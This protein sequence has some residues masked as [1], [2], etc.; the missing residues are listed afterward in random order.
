M[1]LIGLCGYA[2][3]GKNEVGYILEQQHG[4]RRYAF[5]DKL[6]KVAEKLNPP[7][8]GEDLDEGC[9]DYYHCPPADH[10]EFWELADVLDEYGWEGVKSSKFADSVRSLLQGLGTAAREELGAEV[11]VDALFDRLNEDHWE[12]FKMEFPVGEHAVITDVRYPNEV[13]RLFAEGGHLVRIM[14]DGVGPV[15]GH[16]SETAIDMIP[17]D[18]TITNNGTLAHLADQ[19]EE[20]MY[21]LTTSDVRK[22]A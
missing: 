20:L 21:T 11:W 17:A 6:R 4:F 18:F 12:H 2:R 13:E 1:E 19:V 7:V 16:G 22:A 15:N 8:W 14:R 9:G 3:S 5:A 10:G